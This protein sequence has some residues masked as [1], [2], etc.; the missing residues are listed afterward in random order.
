M[1]KGSI[2]AAYNVLDIGIG[3][4]PPISETD[5]KNKAEELERLHAA[6]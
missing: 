4:P 1:Y 6:M 2:S 5:T 3:E